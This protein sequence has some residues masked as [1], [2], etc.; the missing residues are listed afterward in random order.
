MRKPHYWTRPKRSQTP[1]EIVVYDCETWHGQRAMVAG[2]ELHRFRLAACLAYR[3]EAG[4]RTRVEW[5]HTTER[6]SVW[7]FITHRL[8]TS[9]PLWVWG[10]NLPYDIGAAGMWQVITSP[11]YQIR[12]AILEGGIFLL[13]GD[14]EG[15]GLNF[16]DTC[17]YFHC[18]LAALGE[19]LGIPKLKMPQQDEPDEVWA[20]YCM[21]D[22][23]VTAAAVDS[24]MR[25]IRE[26]ELGPW[27]PTAASLAFSAFRTRWMRHRV[28]VH[29]YALPLK[30][31][32]AA[33]YG[34]LVTL[35][36]VGR[37]PP[38]RVHELDVRSMYPHICCGE[39]PT[40]IAGYSERI[41]PDAVEH[42]SNQYAV[43]ADVSLDTRHADYPLRVRGRVYYPTGRFRTVLPPAELAHALS[44]GVVRR[45]HAASWYHR[46]ELFRDYMT[47]L[48]R[49][50]AEAEEGGR[51][52]F[53]T[54]AKLL[55]N[56]LYG[57]TG[58]LAPE[59][60]E[61]G[62][63]ALQLVETRH[64]L[65]HGCLAA[66]YDR[67]PTMESAED[68]YHWL[69]HG[70]HVDTRCYWGTVEIKVGTHEARDSCPAI[71]GAVTGAARCLL[72]SYQRTAGPG[73][74]YYSDTD[75]VW[76]DDEGLRRLDAAGYIRPKEMGYLS[77]RGS[78]DWAHFH[79]PKDY[80]Y[81]LSEVTVPLGR[82][83]KG[84]R[85]D[86]IRAADGG[87]LHL[88]FPGAKTQ[89]VEGREAGV[90]VRLGTKHLARRN[91]RV[92]VGRDGW[93]APLEMPRDLRLIPGLQDV[94]GRTA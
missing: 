48:A 59:W 34:G 31:E 50:R 66:S 15:C 25:L 57:K 12:K 77:I 79:A 60:A 44:E 78:F 65:P 27:Q 70:I 51:P 13:Q 89:I 45:V 26:H 21:R 88:Q 85:P 58:Q 33:Y 6:D 29:N 22:V 91:D 28:L 87:W 90:F 63:E 9:R 8:S 84:V 52:E 62:R 54:L 3:L 2:G 69:E 38:G 14:L 67:P 82:K 42:L 18:S 16:A 17:N 61:W 64:G 23:E 5:L 83:L 1:S 43:I 40:R 80:E 41:G 68:V 20:R 36:K 72:R 53:A 86:S 75:S 94:Y 93:T 19:S 37:T 46:A 49:M 11:R 56:S 92:H 30:L 74:W 55:M 39:L 71:A 32:R 24:V 7:G 10:H 76:V 81:G 4:K 35:A 73:H 47:D